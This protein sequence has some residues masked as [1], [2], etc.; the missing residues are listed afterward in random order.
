M[1]DAPYSMR[2]SRPTP[3]AEWAFDAYEGPAGYASN[4]YYLKVK[5]SWQA[6][7]PDPDG[8]PNRIE[9]SRIKDL[10]ATSVLLD[11]TAAQALV[12]MLTDALAWGH[13]EGQD[14]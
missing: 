14:Q 9:I 8:F 12:D 6:T 2:V 5:A 7:R 1:P 10:R 11:R 4:H 13:E 3:S